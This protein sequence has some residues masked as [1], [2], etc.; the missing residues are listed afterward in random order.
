M[1]FDRPMNIDG[2]NTHV[3]NNCNVSRREATVDNNI[4]DVNIEI[5]ISK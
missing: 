2:G 1:E 4:S 5:P 3:E